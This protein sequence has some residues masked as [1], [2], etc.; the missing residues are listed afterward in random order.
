MND[1]LRRGG[2]ISLGLHASVLLALV[3]ALPGREKLPDMDQSDV[4]VEFD[5]LPEPAQKADTPAPTPAAQPSPQAT[6]APPSVEPPKPKPP[7]PPPRP[8]PRRAA[9]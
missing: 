7:A 8:R 3:L 9:E 5:A 6:A 1:Y 2:L 4:A